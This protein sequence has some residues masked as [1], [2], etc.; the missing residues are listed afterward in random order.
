MLSAADG[1]AVKK[2]LTEAAVSA[3][4]EALEKKAGPASSVQDH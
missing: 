2:S 3:I 1:G 4:V